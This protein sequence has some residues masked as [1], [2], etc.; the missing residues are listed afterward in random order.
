MLNG[1][2]VKNALGES[3]SVRHGFVYHTDMQKAV[4]I[5]LISSIREIRLTEADEHGSSTVSLFVWSGE[6]TSVSFRGPHKELTELL[7]LNK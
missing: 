6:K 3:L 2:T 1:H 5:L 4:T 7:E